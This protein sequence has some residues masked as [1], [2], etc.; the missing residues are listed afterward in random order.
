[1]AEGVRVQQIRD[2]VVQ[3]RHTS[4]GA[5]V[6]TGFV[7][8]EGIVTCSHVIRD[9]G[10]NPLA[11]DGRDVGIYYPEREGRSSIKRR[12]K[13]AA[14]FN[15]YD[16]DVVLLHLVDGSSPL[17][18]ELA[19]KFGSAKGSEDH[20]FRSFGYRRLQNYQG[21][22]AFG[23]I[24]G[25][26]E[27]PGDKK[28]QGEPLMLSSQNIDKGMSGAPVLDTTSNLIIGIIY[29]A[30]D[31]AE[32]SHDRDTGLSVDARVLSLEPLCLALEEN[33]LPRSSSPSPKI[34]Q[35]KAHELVAIRQKII[36]NNAPPSLAEWTGRVQLLKDITS[37]WEDARV[38]IT[39]LI[40]FGGEGKSSLAREWVDQLLAD[41]S[42]PQPEG[43]FW[44]G[45]YERRNVDEFFDAALNYMSGGK[46]DVKKIPSAN[47][48]AQ[49][50]TSMLGAGCYL[51]VLDGLEVL[52]Y[53]DGDMYGAIRSPDLK[54]F[55]EFF[56]SPDHNSFCLVTTRAPLMDLE[57]FIT[58]QHRDV[59]RLLPEDG[60][61]LLR[62][63][64]VQ[65][66]DDELARVV[67]DW[68]GHA[69]TL[70]L[71][72]SY[73]KDH[74]EGDVSQIR[75]IPPPTADEPRYERVHRV[76]RR[77]DDHLLEAEK[78]F[79][80]L[81]SVFRR[82]VE[83][84]AFRIFRAKSK[85]QG[86]SL[87]DPIALLNDSQFEAMVLRLVSYRILRQL[88]RS[89]QYTT[90]PLIRAHYFTL[91]TEG[92]LGHAEEAHKQIKDYYLEKAQGIPD[93]PSLEDLAPLIEV[94]HHACQSGVYDEA[95]GIHIKSIHQGNKFYITQRLSAWETE[96]AIMQDFFPGGN[97]SRDP[98]VSAPISKGWILNEV[99][100]CLAYIGQGKLAAGFCARAL[101]KYLGSEDLT[102]GSGIYQNLSEIYI[103]SG[104]LARSLKASGEA[105]ELARR[106][107]TTGY[108]RNSLAYQ[109]CA[110]H[111]QGDLEKASRKFLG[112]EALEK[113]RDNSVLY[114]YSLRGIYHA[115][116]LRRRGENEYARRVTEA[117]LEITER[118]HVL[119]DIIRCHRVLGDLYADAGEQEEARKSYAKAL[120]IAHR[121]SHR[122]VL[123]EVLKARGRWYAR[124]MR[125][126]EAALG[127]LT[128]AFEYAR[129][130]GYRLYEVDIR[131]GMAWAHLAG[132]DDDLARGEARYALQMS[133]DMGYYWGTVDAKEI[134]ARLDDGES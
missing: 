54:A 134:L 105:L 79:M 56:S 52:Q 132:G 126:A 23:K 60:R 94:V 33:D 103:Y 118:D 109:A 81:F 113:V 101:D 50:I 14:C 1:M 129:A 116:H 30:W 91:L 99:G 8:K 102:N 36:W 67:A 78:A 11:R 114:L 7:A 61:D 65:G 76:L 72:G 42:R 17:G 59:E 13:V 125:D 122:L 49:I 87:N 111:L 55:L 119:Q 21:L 107:K 90:H 92:H 12:A 19:A 34:D 3:I 123:I 9:A 124:G 82:P 57:E 4:T 77:Y 70:S 41:S 112:A 100:L 43:M 98:L 106:A 16:D 58:F 73:L 44:W 71:L 69:L 64:G 32:G 25:H 115:E 45:F 127:D 26:G 51:F 121:I 85:K 35:Q 15:Q 27:K 88:P 47:M 37:D 5:I 128:E 18:P 31:S 22:P 75:K 29:L 108:E 89:N 104:E 53:Q 40:G 74:H 133:Q 83:K 46:I 131:I 66:S 84:D 48:K 6:G 10:V 95:Y 96:L 110:F 86:M 20:D 24:V 130:G 28:F 2:F 120:D 62:K 80:M 63:L 38:R 93:K 117:N 39:G 97:P 68:D